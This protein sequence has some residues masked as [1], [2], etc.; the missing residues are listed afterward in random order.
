[1]IY[2][3][4]GQSGAGK[5]TFCKTRFLTAPF[6]P[7]EGYPVACTR[8]GEIYALGKYGIGIRTE[9]T[10]TLSYSAAP[11]IIQTVKALIHDGHKGILMEGD[12]VNNDKM[13]LFLATVGVPVKL[14]LVT[15]SLRTSMSRLRESGSKITETFVKTTKTKAANR[16]M[17]WGQAFHGEVIETDDRLQG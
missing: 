1:M 5:T 8:S 11:K 9:G 3:V 16:F 12:R 4:I 10:D 15:C 14:Y 2:V 7:V 13:F 6:E 17:K